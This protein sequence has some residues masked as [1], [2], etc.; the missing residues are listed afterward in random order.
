MTPTAIPTFRG[1]SAKIQTDRSSDI[2]IVGPAGTGKSFSV[3]YKIHRLCLANPNVRVLLARKTRTSLTN[4]ALVTFERNVLGPNHPLVIN[5][6]LRRNRQ[7]YSYPNGSEIDIGGLDPNHIDKILSSEYDIILVIQAEEITENDY[8]VLTTRLR[9]GVLSYEQII[10]DC[11]PAN[12]TH[13]IK[14]LID[15]GRLKELKAY[16]Q[17]NPSLWDSVKECWTPRGKRYIDRLNKLTG[18]RALRLALG[19]WASAEGAI[20]ADYDPNVHLIDRFDI[21]ESWPRVISIDFGYT[22]PLSVS[23]YALDPDRRLY[24]YRQ[25]YQ[26]QTLIEDI[27]PVIIELSQGENIV[28]VISDHDAEDRATLLKHGIETI[29]AFKAIKL[30]IEAVQLRLRVAGDGKP[31]LYFLRDS[32]VKVDETLADDHKPLCTEDE[33][34]SYEWS[35]VIEGKPVKDSTPAPNSVDHGLDD[36]RYAVCFVDDVGIELQPRVETVVYYDDEEISPY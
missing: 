27:A 29:A 18:V 36:L 32:L 24:R 26:T 2:V 30:G 20:Y 5:G 23:W 21:P 4:T 14:R 3:L 31:R 19:Q 25:I 35:K 6:P 15:N 16:H 1:S 12:K 7:T 17:D 34:D 28:A 8:E 11:N 10:L 9:G 22:A 33:I 13:W